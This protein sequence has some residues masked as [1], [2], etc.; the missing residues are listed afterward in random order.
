M[1]FA[2]KSV[3]SRGRHRFSEALKEWG[4]RLSEAV[5]LDSGPAAEALKQLGIE[6]ESLVG[7]DPSETLARLAGEMEGL[8]AGDRNYIADALWGGD[9][10]QML[11]L[12]A[13]G[14]EGIR[15]LAAESDRL[16]ATMTDAEAGAAKAFNSLYEQALGHAR[17]RRHQHQRHARPGHDELREPGAGR[18]PSGSPG[19]SRRGRGRS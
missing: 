11:S 3:R 14:E 1:A 12:I 6:A 13:Q 10:N 7:L 4:L 5:N 15:S 9:A 18:A 2:A 19:S 16:G 17:R 8:S